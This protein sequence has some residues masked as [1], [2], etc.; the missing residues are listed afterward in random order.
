MKNIIKMGKLFRLMGAVSKEAEIAKVASAVEKYGASTLKLDFGL[1]NAISLEDKIMKIGGVSTRQLEK[2]LKLGNV[3]NSIKTVFKVQEVSTAMEVKVLSEVYDLPSFHIGRV[4]RGTEK[5]K[6]AMN[7]AP[8]FENIVDPKFTGKLTEDMVNKS[9]KL[10]AALKY[11][12]GKSFKSLTFATVV[13]PVGLVYAIDVINKHRSK[14]SGC[15]RYT[16]TGG[17]VTACKVANCSCLDGSPNV[18]THS[19]VVFCNNSSVPDA[20]K[21]PSCAGTTGYACVSCPPENHGENTLANV[22]DEASLDAVSSDDLIYYKCITASINDA[23]GDIVNENVEDL[24]STVEDVK[25]AVSDFLS[26]L[27]KVG[28]YILY[29][30][31]FFLFVYAVGFLLRK[32]GMGGGR[33]R[34]EPEYVSM[35]NLGERRRYL[36]QF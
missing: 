1:V 27:V 4:E 34:N 20:M 6:S 7:G 14:L 8:D 32:S 13:V 36:N 25:E 33:L 23:I 10:Q 22:D 24:V 5:L 18:N 16:M 30:F 26:T 2:E 21:N 17:V 31:A 12:E 9:S 19:G 29:G 28:I 11:I 35:I 3:I 15:F